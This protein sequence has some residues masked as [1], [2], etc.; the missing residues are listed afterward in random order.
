MTYRFAFMRHGESTGNRDGY[1]QGQ[2]DY[3]LS[4]EGIHQVN[5]L[6]KKWREINIR[7]DSIISSPLKRALSSA[8]IIQNNLNIP[9]ITDPLWMERHRGRQ[10]GLSKEEFHQRFP[11]PAF[12]ELYDP[13]GETGESEWQLY[14]R[15]GKAVQSLFRNPPGSYLI[16]SHGGLLNKVLHFIFGI[17]IQADFQGLHFSMN[18]TATTQIVYDSERNQWQLLDYAQPSVYITGHDH[19]SP[20]YQLTF[21]RHAESQGNVDKIFQGQ[22]ETPLTK[23]GEAQ[24]VGLGTFFNKSK[25]H[26]DKIFSSPQERTLQ[27]A[28]KICDPL[29]YNDIET[30]PFLKEIN[31]GK[32]AGLNGDEINAQFP[33][34]PDRNNP[35]LPVGEN[36]ESWMELYLRGMAFL[37]ELLNEPPGS[38]LIVSHGGILNAILWGILGIPPQ[39]SRR[40]AIFRFENT[41]LCQISYTPHENLF[42]F[43]SLNPD[44]SILE[45]N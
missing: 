17:K 16:V 44:T 15:A 12:I 45:N 26:F 18:N 39:P 4:L 10:Q 13:I 24:A 11:R 27:T 2:H 33:L 1:V 21:V 23:I 7:F 31:N 37:D 42:R 19:P 6:A 34:R 40:S 32:L 30:S 9:L 28:K 38:Y 5:T 35:Y 20:A 43:F 29:N 25:V 36:G 14:L 41:G 8:Q 22:S 3:P